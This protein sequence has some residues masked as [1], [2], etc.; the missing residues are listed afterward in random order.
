LGSSYAE[1]HEARPAGTGACGASRV[2]VSR[3]LLGRTVPEPTE[4]AFIFLIFLSGGKHLK[5]YL[6]LPHF[7]YL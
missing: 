3:V 4:H 2:L 5:C 7:S 6:F 1:A